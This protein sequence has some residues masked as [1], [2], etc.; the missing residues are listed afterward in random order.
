MF[1]KGTQ[2]FDFIKR[3]VTQKL[4]HKVKYVDQIN[5]RL[6]LFEI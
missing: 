2:A 4:A 1:G 6:I 3:N 5:G